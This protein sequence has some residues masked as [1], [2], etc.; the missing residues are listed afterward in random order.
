MKLILIRHGQTVWNQ[1]KRLQGWLDSELTAK[2][3]HDVQTMD[4]PT[5][6]NPKIYSSDLGRAI[7]TAGI[8]AKRLN[9]DFKADPRLRERGFG[10][11]EGEKINTN[12]SLENQNLCCAW[13]AY[14]HR[15]ETPMGNQ[16]CVESEGVFEGRI[17][18]FLRSVYRLSYDGDVVVVSHGEWIR[19]CQNVL[20]GIPSWEKGQGITDN[21]NIVILSMDNMNVL[22][23][24]F[25]VE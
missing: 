12:I 23:S 1:E 24:S 20:L 2:A 22:R 15:Y 18:Q 7:K 19:A 10:L 16:F 8:I 4:L 17:I 9:M 13:L 6:S 5:L 3:L 25:H 14:H 11:L 21:R